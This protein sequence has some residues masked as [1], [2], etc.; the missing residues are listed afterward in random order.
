MPASVAHGTDRPSDP[1]YITTTDGRPFDLSTLEKYCW[2]ANTP[3]TDAMIESAPPFPHHGPAYL[4]WPT[5]DGNLDIDPMHNAY[6]VRWLADRMEACGAWIGGPLTV[7]GCGRHIADGNHRFRAW[8][9]LLE[10]G[11][12]VGVGRV[13]WTGWGCW[14]LECQP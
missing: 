14:R 12:D 7:Y 9:W 11:V 10:R 2:Y 8:R 3:C 5:P 4:L 1:H 6:H 13:E